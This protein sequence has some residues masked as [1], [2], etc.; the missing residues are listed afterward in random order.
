VPKVIETP[1]FLVGKPIF[2]SFIHNDH[3]YLFLWVSK[4]LKLRLKIQRWPSVLPNSGLVIYNGHVYKFLWVF[5][6]N[7]NSAQSTKVFDR[8]CNFAIKQRLK[9]HIFLSWAPY[10][11][12]VIHNGHVYKFLCVLKKQISAQNSKGVSLRFYRKMSVCDKNYPK[13]HFFLAVKPKFWIGF[14]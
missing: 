8:K 5:K 11:R 3:V 14:T 7:Q 2:I 13:L 6:N 9:L 4:N 12:S 10:S 1:Y